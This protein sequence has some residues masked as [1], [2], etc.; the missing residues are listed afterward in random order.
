[1]K[2]CPICDGEMS[3]FDEAM[4]LKKYKVNYWQCRECGFI[5]TDN[6]YWLNEAYSSAIVDADIGLAS[7]NYVMSEL[8]AGI[9]DVC[10]SD[11]KTHLDFGGGYGLFTR[12]MRDKGF[13]FQWYDKYCDNLFAKHFEKNKDYYDV[14]TAYEVF[15]HL[16]NPVQDVGEMLSYG[17]N[18][19]FCTSIVPED[20]KDISSW[21]Y[22]MPYHGQHIS[23][24]TKKSLSI[25]AAKFGRKYVGYGDMHMF[26]K[27]KC[28]TIKFALSCRFK[29]IIQRIWKRKSLLMDDYNSIIA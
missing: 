23:F 4:I 29:K 2:K 16:P 27:K 14:V 9:L 26:T 10:L 21:W 17:D 22:F 18:L 24:Y 20:V 28:S 3:I 5:Q 8:T 1:M 11:S 6:P 15:E 12:L 19:I 13:D 7:R 25:L